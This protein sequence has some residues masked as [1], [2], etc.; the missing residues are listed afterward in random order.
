MHH[1]E[2]MFFGVLNDEV[3]DC[4][5]RQVASPGTTSIANCDMFGINGDVVGQL[6]RVLMMGQGEFRYMPAPSPLLPSAAACRH[7]VPCCL[8]AVGARSQHIVTCAAVEV[9]LQSQYH[10][11]SCSKRGS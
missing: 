9:A 8:R 6:V 10:K 3:V 4:F 5:T 7:H 2:V 1:V 11:A